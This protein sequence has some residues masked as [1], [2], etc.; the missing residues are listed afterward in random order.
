MTHNIVAMDTEGSF[1]RLMY[2]SVVGHYET[3]DWSLAVKECGRLNAYAQ[4]MQE[5]HDRPQYEHPSGRMNL[6]KVEVGG[7]EVVSESVD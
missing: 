5:L 1:I 3:N 6:A 2:L 4:R 7:Y